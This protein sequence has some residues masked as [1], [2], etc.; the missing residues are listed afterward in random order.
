M[1]NLTETVAA[2][3]KATE[4]NER[5]AEW[6]WEDPE[7]ARL[8]AKT[9]NDRFNAIVLRNY[10]DV[11]LSLPGLAVSFKPHPHQLAAVARII[12]EPAVLLAHEVGA[13][14]TAE[15]A[16]G[17]MELRRLGFV[18]KPAIVVPNH[19]LEQFGREFLQLYPQ[20]R[21]LVA[22]RED[23]QQRDGRRTFVGRCA[24]GDWD[25]VIISRSA[26]ERIPLSPDAQ[27]AYLDQELEVLRGW[28]E[29]SKER[30]GLTVKRLER[31]LLQA[32]ERLK[33]K[34][35]GAKDPGVTFEHTGIDYLF[36]DEA[37][38]YKNLRTPSNIPNVAIEGSQRASDMDMKID[39]LRRTRGHRVVTFATATPISNSVAEAYVMQRFLRPDVLLA[40]GLPDFDTWAATF[41][42][43]TTAIELAPDGGR[44]RLQTRFAK[45]C[46]VPEL[47]RMW[48]LSADIKTAED[49]RLP[50]PAIVGGGPETV[51]IDPSPELLAY[52]A[53][54]GERADQVKNRQV[55]PSEDNML[56]IATDGRLAAL[57]PRLVGL[58]TD[59]P[60][61]VD[62][63]A[64]RVAA[65][66]A[67][68]RDDVY[69][70]TH[71]R[72]EFLRGSLQLV[73]CDLSTP[74]DQWNFYAELRDQLATRGV[75]RSVVRFVHEARNDREKAELFAACRAGRVAVLVGST[76]RMGVG[77][78]VQTPSG[79]PAPCGLPMEAGRTSPARWSN[80]PPGKP[81]R[82]GRDY[83]VRYRA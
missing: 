3:E 14:K 51:V 10:D 41:G 26:L 68:H 40:A 67:K 28:I 1:L 50:T 80:P 72:N 24:T 77:T 34:L 69:R 30:G 55:D 44:F 54:L 20:A 46:N 22:T 59:A 37:H 39:W 11:E 29:R 82:R 33:S 15:M 5:F 35:D 19:M 23:L 75:L 66:W 16:M 79:G 61:K 27:A 4:L 47:L 43:V 56:K 6:L 73:F 49:L 42:E 21:V 13:G 45:F 78:N 70:G 12:H 18:T 62:K 36:V 64:D 71:G 58:H 63:V 53:E 31:A 60:G 32:Q 7:R 65:V 74:S 76:E 83:S 25:A 9:Y 52:I 2:Q 8:L 48:H 38:G 81:K 57:D 17:A